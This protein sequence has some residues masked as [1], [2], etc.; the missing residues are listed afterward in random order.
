[1]I[2]GSRSRTDHPADAW[3]DLDIV[4]FATDPALLLDDDR[5]LNHIGDAIITY[6]EST[7]VGTWQERRVLF[8]G[9]HDVDFAVVPAELTTALAGLETT[10]PLYAE[11]SAV[12][13]KGY[14]ILID[15]DQHLASIM[16]R[17]TGPEV[18]TPLPPSQWQ[19]TATIN[20]FWYHCVW[21]A[22]KLRR[23]EMIVA[24]ECLDGYQRRLLMRLIHWQA[25]RDGAVWHGTR[26]MEE[27][28][29]PYISQHLAT[30]WA[31]HNNED[32][33]H[34]LMQMMD[35]VAWLARDIA[36]I[37]NLEIPATSEP[38]VRTWV[39]EISGP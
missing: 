1:M 36:N 10:D 17:M 31:Q 35:L 25:E 6:L 29:H 11:I 27:W 32:I 15:R 19:F 22:K 3:S 26:Y 20:D 39:S 38:S 9:A 37:H 28:A 33:H 5:W 34:A 18:T 30:T 14:R 4:V 23:G 8:A 12:V 2:V 7:A 16:P 24:H 21:I 13:G